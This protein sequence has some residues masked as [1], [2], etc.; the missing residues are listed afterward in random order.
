MK[1]K[2]Y[3][4]GSFM[5]ATL[6]KRPLFSWRSI[7]SA[8]ELLNEGML[9]RIRSGETVNIWGDKWMPAPTTF[10]IQSPKRSFSEHAKVAELIDPD[11]KGWDVLMINII[12][13]QKR[14]KLSFRFC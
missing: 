11:T 12:S 10:T 2:Y 9:W 1:P 4:H 6:C 13:G 7:S 3:P 14:P 5:E 8:W